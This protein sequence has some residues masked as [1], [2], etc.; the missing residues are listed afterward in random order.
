MSHTITD[1]MGIIAL[2]KICSKTGFISYRKQNEI[3]EG[4]KTE[5]SIKAKNIFAEVASLSGGNQQKICIAKGLCVNPQIMIIDEPTVGIDVQTKAEIHSLIYKLAKD[6]MSII[7]IS[8]DLS[9]LIGL[10]DRVIVFR[11]NEI[12]GQYNNTKNYDDMSMQI[13]EQILL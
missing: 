10:V 2:D 5:L 11:D 1:N 7:V 8:S 9:E 3:T 4:Y 12:K 13:M 6:G